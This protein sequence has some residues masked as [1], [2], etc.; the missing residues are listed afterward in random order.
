MARVQLVI[1]D[2]DHDRF[3]LQARREGMTLSA[4]LCTADYVRLEERRHAKSFKSLEDITAFFRM[5]DAL[6]GPDTE[7][8]RDEYLRVINEER[9][10]G[11]TG[12]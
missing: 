11:A 12:T 3:L 1:P 10:A 9:A 6:E 2:A 5:C 4:W 7:P 8:D